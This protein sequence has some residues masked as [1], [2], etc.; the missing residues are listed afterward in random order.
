MEDQIDDAAARQL[1]NELDLMEAALMHRPLRLQV[2]ERV[3]P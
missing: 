2:G 1:L 3:D